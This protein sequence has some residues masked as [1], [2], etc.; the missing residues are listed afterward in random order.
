M[1]DNVSNCQLH[2]E[3]PSLL[4]RKI[5]DDGQSPK[6]QYLWKEDPV[7]WFGMLV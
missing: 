4:F 2:K 6:A 3:D 5:P 7:L 1:L